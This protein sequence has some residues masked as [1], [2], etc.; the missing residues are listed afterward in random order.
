MSLFFPTTLACPKCGEPVQFQASASVNA[1]RR[2]D[3]RDEILNETFQRG[4]C[5]KCSAVFRLDPQM[6][7]LDVGRGQ[8]LAA[9]PVARFDEWATKEAETR[10]AFAK[11]YGDQSS[12]AAQEIGDEL[13]PRLVFGWAAVREK[14]VAAEQQLDDVELELLK[15]SLLRGMDNPP[16]APGTELR[17][18]AVDL[19][20]NELVLASFETRSGELIEEL[21]V[22]RDLYD[23][24]A[25]DQQGWQPLRDDLLAGLFVDY[26]RLL[27]GGGADAPT[28]G[29][30]SP[31]PKNQK[32]ETALKKPAATGQKTQAAGKT[33]PGKSARKSPK[34]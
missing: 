12:P 14:L 18:I 5:G 19:A 27:T 13:K 24:I 10:A 22:P 29:K 21:R 20:E 28:E 32:S 15:I 26:R 7:Y 2:P 33:K 23:E 11:A 1:D 30:S 34:R 8:W 9:F 25:G 4:T 16:L 31:N 3:L 17:L 6:N